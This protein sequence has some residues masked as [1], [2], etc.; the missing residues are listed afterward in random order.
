MEYEEVVKC[1]DI[2]MQELQRGR[3]CEELYVF[4][5]NLLASSSDEDVEGHKVDEW[6]KIRELAG[7][8]I[9]A[10]ALNKAG[11]EKNMDDQWLRWEKQ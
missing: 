6:R 1:C 11:Y 3:T 2:Y 9:I 7:Y 4:Y 10:S 8:A 5:D